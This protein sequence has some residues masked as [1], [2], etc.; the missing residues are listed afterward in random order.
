AF[1]T[2]GNPRDRRRGMR[3]R[4]PLMQR[5]GRR[6]SAIALVPALALFAGACGGDDDH[7]GGGDGGGD[8]EPIKV[9]FLSTCEG[10]FGAFYEATAGGFNV[11]LIQRGAEPVSDTP[12]DGVEG[13]EIAGR[14]IEV[15]GY[16]CSDET[17][18]VAVNEARRLVE[19]EGADILVGPLSG[20]EGIAI[21]NYAKEQPD[22]TFVNGAAGAQDATHKV[23]APNF[24]R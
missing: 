4:P 6:L 7:G 14:P 20:D 2:Q 15:V 8:G 5:W 19:Q 21:A 23:Q 18:E 1:D 11:P 3:D 10:A 13:A 22:K 17:P 12:S 9:G 24:F 16:G